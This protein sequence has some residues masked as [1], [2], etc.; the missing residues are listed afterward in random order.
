MLCCRTSA[1]SRRLAL[2]QSAHTLAN[3]RQR[4]VFNAAATCCRSDQ[5]NSYSTHSLL[6]P[7]AHTADAACR[8]VPKQ[9]DARWVAS[10]GRRPQL[11]DLFNPDDWHPGTVT[12]Q[13]LL[14]PSRPSPANAIHALLWPGE[15]V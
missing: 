14:L 12:P 1:T 15:E 4:N 8:V 9:L 13:V 10:R 5:G 6:L 11:S 2:L 7:A 3:G